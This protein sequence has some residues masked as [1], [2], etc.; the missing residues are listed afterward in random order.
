MTTI[1]V[2]RLYVR[3]DRP[4]TLAR[5]MEYGA[6]KVTYKIG[7]DWLTISTAS[8]KEIYRRYRK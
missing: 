8:F 2:G 1:K 4:R 5:V 6:G 3:R 7:N